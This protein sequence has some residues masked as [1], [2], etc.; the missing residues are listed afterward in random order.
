MLRLGS[1]GDTVRRAQELLVRHP[2]ARRSVRPARSARGHRLRALGRS[3]P[4]RH[5]GHQAWV[6]CHGVGAGAL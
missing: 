4:W 1:T 6:V 3:Q 2:G 5:R